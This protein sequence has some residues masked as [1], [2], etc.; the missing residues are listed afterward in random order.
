MAGYE[1]FSLSGRTVLVAGASRG[2]GLAIAREAAAAG[3]HTVLGARSVGALRDE[4]VKL[5]DQGLSAVAV[6]LDVTDE[7][8]V[9]ETMHTLPVLD[10]LVL[11]AG[12]N[13][14][15]RFE[16]YTADEY[17]HILETNLHAQARLARLA[18]VGML[19]R[20]EGGKIIFI[21]S[22]NQVTSLPYLALYS[23]TKAALGGLTRALAA[24]WGQHDIQVNCIA[25]GLIWTDLTAPVWGDPDIAAWREGVQPTPRWGTPEDI[26]PLAVYLLGSASDFVT[27]QTLAVDG[28]YTTTK[29]WPFRPADDHPG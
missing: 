10:G 4:A 29:V 17:A 19:E 15:K 23:M 28:G 27:G 21:G 11:V 2:I 13:I 1:R 3:A 7:V 8:A 20:G 5:T 25:P 6:E 9:T 16:T 26:A 24:E 18:G 12:T 22:S 14:R